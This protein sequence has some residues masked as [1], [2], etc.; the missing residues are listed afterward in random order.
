MQVGPSNHFLTGKRGLSK[1][2]AGIPAP[3]GWLERVKIGFVLGLIGF[4]FDPAFAD[5][6]SHLI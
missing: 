3:P 5:E 1:R 2:A 6:S 4:V